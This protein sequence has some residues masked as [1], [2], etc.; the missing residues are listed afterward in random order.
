VQ[1]NPL[2]FLESDTTHYDVAILALCIWYFGSPAEIRATLNVLAKRVDR[3]CIA[4]W[5]LSS[6][7]AHTHVLAALTQGALECH[8]PAPASNIRTIASP[9][10]IRQSAEELGWSFLKETTI[11]PSEHVLDGRWEVEHVK[12]PTFLKDIDRFIADERQRSV[13]IALR[14]AMLASL[15]RVGGINK[16]T[17]M[18]VWCAVF[19]R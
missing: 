7:T 11:S 8:N 14:D 15:E 6:P 12:N 16:V 4:E 2:E 19:T 5:S 10:F 9:A 1:A 13:V 17:S 3:I 18:D